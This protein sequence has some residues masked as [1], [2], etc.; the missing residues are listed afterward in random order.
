MLNFGG[1]CKQF[2]LNCLDNPRLNQMIQYSLR[3]IQKH[4]TVL[5]NILRKIPYTAA[6]DYGCG[7]GFFAD[8]F[9]PDKYL[10]FDFN[11]RRIA[12]AQKHFSRYSF[13]ARKPDFRKFDL[14][15]FNNVWHHLKAAQI[16]NLLRGLAAGQIALLELKP[17]NEQRGIFF[18]LILWLEAKT[19]YSQPRTA[20]FYIELLRRRGFVLWQ[21]RDLGRFFLQLYCFR[22]V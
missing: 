1:V 15:L 8:C 16:K 18:K 21:S 9:T 13:T 7:E 17:P 19:H 10:G 12:Y 5:K 20:V 2:L 14:L 11:P 3:P 22:K 6:L 4:K